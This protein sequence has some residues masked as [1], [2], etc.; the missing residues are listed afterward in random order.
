MANRIWHWHFG[1]G[2]VATTND[3]GS[4]GEPPTH[5]ELLDWLASEFMRA[6]WSVKHMHRLVMTSSTYRMSSR[7]GEQAL[8]LDPENKLLSR[9]NRHRLEAEPLY[10]AMVITTNTLVR[11]EPGEPLDVN[12]SKK[13]MMYTLTSGTSPK[14]LGAEVRKMFPLFDCELSGVPVGE[15]AASVTAAQALFWMNSPLVK[16]HADKFA[17]RLLKMDKLDDPKRLN[18][19]YMLALGRMPGKDVAEQTL[20]YLKQCVEQDGLSRQDS[21]SQVC[22]ALYASAEFHYLE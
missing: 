10:D 20:A 8:K 22:Q 3:F 1:R 14:G 15:R 5:P 19:A 6:G 7:P 11:Q 13:R 21:W 16:F 4:R 18:E 17:E 9:Y 2:I 12:R